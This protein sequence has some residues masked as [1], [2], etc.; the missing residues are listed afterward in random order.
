MEYIKIL[1]DIKRE[2]PFVD[3]KPYSHNIINMKLMIL[4]EMF[5]EDKVKEIVSQTQLKYLGWGYV[6]NE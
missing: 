3:V 6:L 2:I 5:G 1:D 4:G